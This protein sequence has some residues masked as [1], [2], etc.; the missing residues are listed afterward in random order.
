[1]KLWQVATLE[2]VR[3]PVRLGQDVFS[4]GYLEHETIQQAEIA[5]L[6]FKHVADKYGVQRMRAVAT[7]AAREASNSDLLIDR[8]LYASGIELEIISGRR[9]W[10]DPSGG[11]P[12][13]EPKTNA[14]C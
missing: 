3:L 13:T 6:R 9:R 11:H 5:F 7:S 1:M 12:C 8:V 10:A 4:K 14:P 2:N